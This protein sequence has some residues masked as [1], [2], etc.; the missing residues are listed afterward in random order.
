MRIA[1]IGAGFAGLATTYH[2]LNYT[3][4]AATVDIYDPQ[5]IGKNASGISPG[6][7]H[8]FPGKRAQTPWQV[9]AALKAAHELLTVGS[10]GANASVI[11]EKGILRPAISE[12]QI[13]DFKACA[14]AYPEEAEW[15]E[16]EKCLKNIPGLV[17]ENRESGGLYI[18]KGLTIDVQAYLQGLWQECALL[19]TQ[20]H[21][22]AMVRVEE[23]QKYDHILFAVGYAVKQFKPL[24]NLPITP[25]KG[26]ILELFWPANLP[27]LP[28]SLISSGYVVMGRDKKHCL[29]GTTHERD[30]T[31]PEP[32]PEVAAPLIFEKVNPFFPGLQK[33]AVKGC[34][35]GIR[36][37]PGG[38]RLPI[39][40]KVG[41]KLWF[42]TGLGGKG[43]LYHAFLGDKLAQAILSDDPGAIPHEVRHIAQ[44]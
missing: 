27:P 9:N 33:A 41:K 26:Q 22:E 40:G 19:G 4:A 39:L 42:I 29:V 43:L 37:S 13:T 7:L 8:P 38:K 2:I 32:E 30:F 28:Y 31:S 23:F 21:N 15:W 44:P 17:L 25:V 14:Y 6:L 1:V 20:I 35:A 34:R 5:P 10:K 24:E 16:R 11:I 36:A 3:K 12:Q 18:K